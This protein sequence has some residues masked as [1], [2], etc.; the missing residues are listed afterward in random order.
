MKP[1]TIAL[2]EYFRHCQYDKNLNKLTLKAYKQDL[3]QF[4][5]LIGT[6]TT[7]TD[8]TKENIRNYIKALFDQKLKESS[9]K[10]KVA[11]LK[12]FLRF[13]EYE[14]QILVSPFR[15]LNIQIRIPKRVPRFLSLN[16]VQVL[17]YSVKNEL[18]L[19]HPLRNNVEQ[20]GQA[21][22]TKYYYS[23]Q[24]LVILEILFVSGVRVSELCNLN[25]EDIDLNKKVIK[26]SGKGSKE[27]SVVITHVETIKTL[28][29]FITL[30]RAIQVDS[31]ALLINRLKKR[32]QT[33][34]IRNMLKNFS[35]E[36]KLPMKT[37][38]HMFRHTVATL[39][40]EN[41]IDTRF[42][43]KFLGH[44]SIIT[45]QIYTHLSTN[46]EREMISK[47]HPRNQL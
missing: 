37:T 31:G 34:S 24:K 30:R 11:S 45:T 27:R 47:N 21:G 12:A 7:I 10:R 5:N 28:S 13:L 38:P 2:D 26:V 4:N 18:A 23:L 36:T 14:D 40:I 43:Q 22:F 3:T 46:A 1:I 39:L 35:T 29:E 9:I 8:L 16:D 17:F 20:D 33:Q 32:M 25:I 6:P 15:K 42:V 44:S 19:I 41:G